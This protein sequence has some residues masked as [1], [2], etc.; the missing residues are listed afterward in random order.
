MVRNCLRCCSALPTD[1]GPYDRSHTTGPQTRA[2]ASKDHR[3]RMP[4][5]LHS[6][7]PRL[8]PG[9]GPIQRE[10]WD[11][12]RTTR[13]PCEARYIPGRTGDGR[14]CL[15]ADDNLHRERQVR[16]LPGTGLQTGKVLRAADRGDIPLQ[17]MRKAIIWMHWS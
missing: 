16:S 12:E 1:I 15:E 5:V 10:G 6:I 13:M 11:G 4:P 3:E 7:S 17:R 9:R 14:R 2:T 8:V